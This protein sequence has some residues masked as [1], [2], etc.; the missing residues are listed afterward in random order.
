ME[1]RN[2][3]NEDERVGSHRAMV[4]SGIFIERNPFDVYRRRKL[5]LEEF[6]PFRNVDVPAVGT[7]S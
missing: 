4:L 2:G 5:E 3:A 6:L 7:T 1:Q